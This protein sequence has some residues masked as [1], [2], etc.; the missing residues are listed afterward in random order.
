MKIP[1]SGKIPGPTARPLCKSR[2]LGDFSAVVPTHC[3]SFSCAALYRV[4]HELLC[5]ERRG[6]KHHLA[7]LAAFK[8]PIAQSLSI[9]LNDNCPILI[10]AQHFDAPCPITFQD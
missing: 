3:G 8:T 5:G 7:A 9:G 2:L 10:S 6:L 1:I 4:V